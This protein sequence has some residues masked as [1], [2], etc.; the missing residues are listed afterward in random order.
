MNVMKNLLRTLGYLLTR[1]R[2]AEE[3]EIEMEFHREMMA[4]EAGGRE[5]GVRFGNELQLREEAR[6]AWGWMWV[7]R[8]GQDLRYAARMLRKS[9]GFTLVAVMLLAL[10]I[11]V[12]LAAFGFFNLMT[13]RPLDVKDAETLVRL[14]RSSPGR[15]AFA[16][17]YREVEFVSRNTRTLEA[18][19]AV[20]GTRLS[21]EGVAVSIPVHFVTANF[22]QELGATPAI[23][24]L[25]R[26]PEDGRRDAEAVAVVSHGF[27]QSHFGGA[28]DVVGRE[29]RLNGRRTRVVGVAR[30]QFSGLSLEQPAVWIG[31]EKQPEFVAGSQLLTGYTGGSTEVKMY[32]RRKAGMKVIEEEMRRILGELRRE[33]PT[34]I[35]EG[36]TLRVEAA[37][38]VRGVASG[39]KSGTGPEPGDELLPMMGLVGALALLILV[40]ACGNLGSL[41]LARSVAR[42]REMRIRK[43]LGAGAA[44]LV[45]QLF[46][47]SLVLGLLG[48]AAG[49]GLG[50]A[51]LRLLLQVSQAPVW[52]EATPDWRVALFGVGMGFAAAI[53]FGLTP[54]LQVARDKHRAPRVRQVLIAVQVAASCVLLVVSGLLVRALE[55]A[56]RTN[57]GFEYEQVVAVDANL[58]GYGYTPG[59]ARVYFEQ[60]KSRLRGGAGV[61]AMALVSSTPLGRRSEV[62]S[63]DMDGRKA[64]VH[65]QRVDE[66][67]FET[68]QIRMLRGR[69]LAAGERN[70][71]VVSEAMARAVWP[72][73]EPLGKDLTMGTDP[74]GIA[75]R[76]VVV[77]VAASVRTVALENSDAME[78]YF[79]AQES[80][81]PGMV[82]LVRTAGAPEGLVGYL[83]QTARGVDPQVFAE[84][85]TLKASFQR[86]VEGAEKSAVAVGVLGGLSLFLAAMGIVGLVGYSVSQ[87][88]KEIGVRLALGAGSGH[89]LGVVLQQFVGPVGVG[90]IVGMGGAVGVSRLLR[91]ML[92]G[93]D[94]LDPTAYAG[95]LGVFVAS[96]TIAALVPAWRALRVE[97]M[98]ALRLE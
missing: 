22:F 91:Q 65:V 19:M 75:V 72:G 54:A 79:A 4:R 98:G 49:M 48:S 88:T 81:L 36:E 8:L 67:F 31:M 94:P 1:R 53:L 83:Q 97:P 9:P 87:R 77:G 28:G 14:H 78:A 93:V 18:V 35:W 17:P 74:N 26:E 42:E 5:G 85:E 24:R 20:H 90:L 69:G 71:L 3:L 62:L 45:R 89:V 96:I 68:M 41:L 11:G 73:E 82:L 27:W 51:V 30:E 61:E 2:Q 13:L 55:Q 7:D 60:L 59:A 33:Q 29:L 37:G 6:E 84:V 66:G 10:G 64:N 80:D 23:G 70:T 21:L 46:T 25:L 63:M 56:V 52:M 38:F 16:V 34:A 86:K 50:W 40:V 39:N 15:Y 47:E 43:N 92:F 76:Y 95:A 44:R 32:G 12:N 57:P 58:P